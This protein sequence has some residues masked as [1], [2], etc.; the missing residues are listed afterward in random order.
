VSRED[1]ERLSEE[2]VNKYLGSAW[3]P[4]SHGAGSLPPQRGMPQNS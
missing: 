2:D 1:V 4:G 3:T